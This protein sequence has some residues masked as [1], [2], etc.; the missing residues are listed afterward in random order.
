MKKIIIVIVFL[1]SM[2][3]FSQMGNNRMM[4]NNQQNIPSNPEREK[5][6]MEKAKQESLEKLMARLSTDLNLDALQQVA[7]KQI[8][9]ENVKKQ[10]IILKK[11]ISEEDKV[12]LLKSLTES[13]ELKVTTLLN[14]EQKEKY[15]ILKKEKFT[16]PTKKKKK[17]EK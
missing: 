17:K 14:R 10:G 16:P 12:A 7:I 6:D 5:E 9:S 8:Y 1:F 11:E 4:Q 3:A 2:N 15:D 13:T